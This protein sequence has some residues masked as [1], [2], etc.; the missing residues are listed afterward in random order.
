MMK[1]REVKCCKC[2]K[3]RYRPP[4]HINRSSNGMHYCKKCWVETGKI[5][6]RKRQISQRKHT[7][8]EIALIRIIGSIVP[9]FQTAKA[10]SISSAGMIKLIIAG[11]AYKDVPSLTSEGSFNEYLLQ[12]AACKSGISLEGFRTTTIRNRNGTKVVVERSGIHE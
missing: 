12:I 4:T 7:P 8:E 1:G 3:V 5:W 10:I 2:G 11:K 6:L 9:K